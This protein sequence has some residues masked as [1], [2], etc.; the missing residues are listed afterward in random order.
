MR[1]RLGEHGMGLPV[2]LRLGEMWQS[3]LENAPK[4]AARIV[5]PPKP[6]ERV[7]VPQPRAQIGAVERNRAR[8]WT[9][10]DD[11]VRWAALRSGP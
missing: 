3:Q 1:R 7:R 6:I 9:A 5:H 8:L 4:L 11:A 10:L 2:R